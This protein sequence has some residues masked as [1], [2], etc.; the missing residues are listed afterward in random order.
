MKIILSS[1]SCWN[2]YNFRKNLIKKLLDNNIE[3][4]ILSPED[5]YSENLIKMGCKFINIKI[6]TNRISPIKDFLLLINYF[7]ILKVLKPDFFFAFTIKP[8]IYGSLSANYLNIKVIN[9]IT[10]LGTVFFKKNL[11]Q[12]F[13]IYLY[14]ISMKKSF[15]IFFQNFDNLS[16]FKKNKIVDNN[17]VDT[18]AGSGVDL[19]IFKYTPLKSKNSESLI[20]LF[21]GR[22]LWEKGIKEYSEAIKIIKIKFPK[23]QFQ[24]LGS[25]D[26]NNKSSVTY[27]FIKKLENASLI[28]YLGYTNNVLKHIQNCD[29]VILPSYG[30]GMPKS[31]LEAC[32]VGRPIIASNV[33]GC[34]DIVIEGKNG[35]F[36]EPKNSESLS[37]AIFKF[38]SLNNIQRKKLGTFA[39][40]FIKRNFDENLVINKYTDIVFNKNILN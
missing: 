3:I 38:I 1:N 35:F 18:I 20:F 12:Y 7:N 27:S 13:V 36:C 28:K 39:H 14:K 31:L 16:F 30:E 23:V 8:N 32:A 34:K 9:N 26:T 40:I 19:D 21:F 10:G 4:Y 37:K 24:I 5:D 25:I 22:L 33:S 15:K 11:I 6:E 29:C 17:K 2:L